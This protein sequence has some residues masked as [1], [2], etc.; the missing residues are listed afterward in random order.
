MPPNTEYVN[1]FIGCETAPENV[2]IIDLRQI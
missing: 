2:E 1:Y